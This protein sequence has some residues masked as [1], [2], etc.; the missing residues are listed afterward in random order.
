M[1]FMAFFPNKHIDEKLMLRL[2]QERFIINFIFS[3]ENVTRLMDSY[4][5]T[6][7]YFD[8]NN[9][10]LSLEYEYSKKSQVTYFT[11]IIENVYKMVLLGNYDTATALWMLKSNVLG[12]CIVSL[13]YYYVSNLF[14]TLGRD[15]D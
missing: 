13:E 5:I 7:K 4:E 11:Q 2:G 8:E 12:G 10:P 1:K 14:I 15:K 6:N 9:A 3:K